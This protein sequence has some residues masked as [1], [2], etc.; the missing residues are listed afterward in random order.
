[1][2]FIKSVGEAINALELYVCLTVKEVSPYIIIIFE[3]LMEYI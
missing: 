2:N 1:M 3:V